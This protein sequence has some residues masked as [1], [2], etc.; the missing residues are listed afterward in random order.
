MNASNIIDIGS[1]L[2][3]FVD[4]C[5]IARVSGVQRRLHH[6]IPQEVVMVTDQ[7]WEGNACGMVTVF[8]DEGRY[9]MYY[10]GLQFA[11]TDEGKHEPHPEYTCYAE[12]DD[13]VHWERPE[14]GLVEHEGS[15]KNNIVWGR[16]ERLGLHSLSPFRDPNP[17]A[18]EDARY[19]SWMV[20]ANPDHEG[21]PKTPGAKGLFPMKS[22]DGFHW[23]LAKDGPGITYGRFDSH[24]V[25]FWDTVRSEYR[26]YHRNFL[27]REPYAAHENA[28]AGAVRGTRA[29]R[30]M[31]T[32]TS[33]GFV[34]WSDSVFL[35]YERGK[36]D[37]LYTNSIIPYFRA[38]HIFVGFPMRYIDRGWS[39]AMEDLPELEHRRQRADLVVRYGSALTDAMFMSSRDGRHFDLW[40][41]SFIR[42]GLR[43][44]DNWTYA[45]NLPNWGLVTTKS[46][47]AGAPD[48]L[49]I[50]TIEGY[51]RGESL[52]FRRHTLRMDGFVSVQAPASGGELVTK[53]VAFSGHE[54]VL[55]FSAS[56]AG[57]VKVEILQDEEDLP[58]EGYTLDDCR[59]IL[60][61]DLERRV[62]WKG[63][64][65]VSR[66][67]GVPIRLR[68]VMKDADLFAFGF[69]EGTG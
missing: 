14:L 39:D 13:G 47:F 53:P 31:L 41:E 22:S 50:Y 57:S 25:C 23:E 69:R 18:T 2:E 54:L 38:P 26:S 5:L 37:E 58:I 61:D 36:P 67:A 1:R 32:A 64:S 51:W 59:E 7:P 29:Q 17:A 56:A 8:Q 10:R 34:E 35:T 45:D 16:E 55:N 42:P 20:G 49:S 27:E 3:L 15:K 40:H 60:G 48:E 63:S 19:K 12:S 33:Q 62:V 66:L 30:D 21:E 43:P 44:Q 4:D 52:N 9:R 46:R 24:N 65:D 11:L 28:A 68:F 6:P